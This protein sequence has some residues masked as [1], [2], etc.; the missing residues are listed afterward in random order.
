MEVLGG[1]KDS[2]DEKIYNA[3]KEQAGARRLIYDSDT[4]SSFLE[5]V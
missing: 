5:L 4:V 3:V 1:A 2:L